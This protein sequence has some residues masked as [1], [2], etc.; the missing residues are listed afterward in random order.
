[1]LKD[2]S[3]PAT[4]AAARARRSPLK[5][6][7]SSEA[8][9]RMSPADST[10]RNPC[11]RAISA[12][13]TTSNT[14]P[15]AISRN[16]ANSVRDEREDPSARFDPTETAAR[17]ICEA[18]PN[19]S[20]CGKVWVNRYTTSLKSMALCQAST[21]SKLNSKLF[22]PPFAIPSF[23]LSAFSFHRRRG[24]NRSFARRFLDRFGRR[25]AE[26]QQDT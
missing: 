4:L 20:S 7:V 24:A 19:L 17:R 6:L 25:I 10:D 3:Q 2:E 15:T 14:E 9:Q 5:I 8:A 13:A 26:G 11:R 12:C 21:R 23:Q 18:S 22:C 16:R 1:M